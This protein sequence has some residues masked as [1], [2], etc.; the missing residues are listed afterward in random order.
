MY[1]EQEPRQPYRQPPTAPPPQQPVH[2]KRKP[3]LFWILIPASLW[4]L[5]YTLK[6]SD[7]VLS[8]DSILSALGIRNKNMF[9][10]LFVMMAVA[11]V[12]I[13]I[14]KALKKK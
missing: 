3:R 12:A 13:V 2:K 5:H 7:C 10:Q 14:L 1:P 4:L 9:T 8:W 11:T 6:N